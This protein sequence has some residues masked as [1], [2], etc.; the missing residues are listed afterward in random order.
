M[1]KLVRETFRVKKDTKWA[2]INLVSL[3]DPN[4]SPKAKFIHI[5]M[6]SRPPNWIIRIPDIIKRSTAGRDAIYNGINE[7]IKHG[8]IK[9]EADRDDVG[10]I[11][12]WVYNIY[13]MPKNQP[14]PEKPDLAEPDL[15]EPDAYYY[16]SD[17]SKQSK[18]DVSYETSEGFSQNPLNLNKKLRLT[19]KRKKPPSDNNGNGLIY[20][21]ASAK[22]NG[23]GIS[24]WKDHELDPSHIYETKIAKL[25]ERIVNRRINKPL[26]DETNEV[27]DYWNEYASILSNNGNKKLT[28]HYTDK[29]TKTYYMHKIIVTGLIGTRNF[30]MK[31]IKKAIDNYVWILQN[32]W[33]GKKNIYRNFWEFYGNQNL[34]GDCI[35][36]NVKNNRKYIGREVEKRTLT[37][38]ELEDKVRKFHWNKYRENLDIHHWKTFYLPLIKSG[39]VKSEKD[40]CK[41]T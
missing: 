24:V 15:A 38:D 40:F 12:K 33:Y 6:I 13:E 10:K 18:K 8:Y 29:D 2:S 20:N 7:L 9:R 36:D 32:S 34:F 41:F 22:G 39:E 31:D 28:V 35:E 26:V 23:N 16:N 5:Y 19:I 1:S 14:L 21:S 17:S 30:L 3:E 11:K 27:L 25:R 37:E 4:L